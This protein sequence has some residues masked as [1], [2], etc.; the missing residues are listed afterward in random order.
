MPGSRMGSP[1]FSNREL[2]L[3]G[4]FWHWK[5]RSYLWECLCHVYVTTP[6]MTPHM[7]M[8][9]NEKRWI[10]VK[11]S[12]GRSCLQTS[13][14]EMKQM[15]ASLPGD[16]HGILPNSISSIRSDLNQLWLDSYNLGIAISFIW[17]STLS[18]WESKI[19]VSLTLSL[20][21][22]RDDHQNRKGVNEASAQ[23]WI[24]SC[25]PICICIHSYKTKS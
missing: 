3:H 11:A 8:K 23:K 17:A 5:K 20:R 19:V 25:V 1:S 6:Y 16:L 18:C 22:C 15:M 24:T 21:H 13:V 12:R 14:T 9:T 10:P 2:N 4:Y 7:Y